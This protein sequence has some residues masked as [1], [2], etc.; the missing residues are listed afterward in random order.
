M[1]PLQILFVF[2]MPRS[3]ATAPDAQGHF[4][5][6]KAGIEWVRIPGGSFTMG[7]AL[8]FYDERP[9]HRVT[10][11]AFELARA[12][13][14]NRQYR[15]CVKAGACHPVDPDCMGPGFDGDEQPVVCVDWHQAEAFSRWVGGRLPSE[16]EWE[17]AARS[18]GQQEGQ[19]DQKPPS[20]RTS[21]LFMFN[22]GYGCGANH[23]WNVCSKSEGDT[24]QGICD[25]LGN[26]WEWVQ[27]FYHSSYADAPADGRAWEDAPGPGRVARGGSWLNEPNEALVSRRVGAGARLAYR[28][29]GFRPAR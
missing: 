29:L 22:T 16:A 2:M 28:G 4:A 25:M 8:G 7:D 26:V 21:V 5:A 19:S 12:E 18:A 15:A 20:C 13:V 9:A 3:W 14:T 27:D 24:A 17:Y 1:I 23:T 6:G 10:V 11:R